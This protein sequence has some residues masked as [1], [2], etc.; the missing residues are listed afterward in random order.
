MQKASI[1]DVEIPGG[2]TEKQLEL[3]GR[4]LSIVLP[5]DADQLLDH[6]ERDDQPLHITDPYWARLWPT[7]LTMSELVGREEWSQTVRALELG[8][9]IGIVGLAALLAGLKVTFSDYVPLA[10]EL[11]CENACRNHLTHFDGLV[12]DWNNPPWDKYPV[13]LA[14]DVLYDPKLHVIVLDLLGCVLEQ[15]GTCWIGDPGRYHCEAFV[16]LAEHHGFAVS[17]RDERGQAQPRVTVGE[18]CLLVMQR[19]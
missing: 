17:I 10:V 12:F 7:A 2:W 1:R 8:C 3:A 14:S 4:Q 16:R 6:L 9:G 18:F 13:I 5:T 15:R 19:H 11:A